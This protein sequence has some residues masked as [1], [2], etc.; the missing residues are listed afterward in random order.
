LA[1]SDPKESAKW[2][3]SLFDL[4]EYRSSES[5]VVLGNDAIAISLIKGTPDPSALTHMAFRTS[6]M[7]SL[8][9]AR[10]FLRDKRVA[11]E[12]PGDEIGPVAEGSASL[13]IWFR[14]N[15]GYRWELYLAAEDIA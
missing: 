10:D 14:D 5:R 15:D 4:E 12:D 3:L 8:K 9:S 11:L 2:W 13:G 1:V 6:D 7:T